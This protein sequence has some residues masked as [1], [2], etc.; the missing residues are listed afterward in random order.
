MLRRW[1]FIFIFIIRRLKLLQYMES[2]KYSED[3]RWGGF[4]RRVLVR[5]YNLNQFARVRPPPGGAPTNPA[6]PISSRKWQYTR[7]QR[8]TTQNIIK[9]TDKKQKSLK[10]DKSWISEEEIKNMFFQQ[11]DFGAIKKQKL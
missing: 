4:W 1:T 7:L 9:K 8:E 10:K 2:F 11:K 5:C 3:L 6:A